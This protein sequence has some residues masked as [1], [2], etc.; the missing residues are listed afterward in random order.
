MVL[1]DSPQRMSIRHLRFGASMSL[2]RGWAAGCLVAKERGQV[3]FQPASA[4]LVAGVWCC[5]RSQTGY[6]SPASIIGATDS[7]PRCMGTSGVAAMPA[8]VPATD[9]QNSSSEECCGGLQT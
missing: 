8:A 6:V 2:A 1:G 3:Y 9:L 5:S 7:R 4:R